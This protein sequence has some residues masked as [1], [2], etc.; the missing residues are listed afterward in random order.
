MPATLAIQRNQ[1]LLR[2]IPGFNS[3]YVHASG[4][5]TASNRMGIKVRMKLLERLQDVVRCVL[6]LQLFSFGRLYV[7]VSDKT[8]QCDE[9]A[10]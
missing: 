9:L 10:Q 4:M 1:F 6:L 8:S 5:K 2:E 7:S 3:L